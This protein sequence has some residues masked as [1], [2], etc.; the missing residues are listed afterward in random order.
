MTAVALYG[1]P[2]AGKDTVTAALSALDPRFELLTKLKQ[3]TGRSA[4]YRFVTEDELDDLRAQ[5][6][7]LVETRRYGNVYAVDRHLLEEPQERGRVPVVHMGNVTDLRA[8]LSDTGTT[9]L[10]VLLWVP[11]EVCEARSRARNDADTVKRL[12]A[13]DET[14]RDLVDSDLRDLFDVVVRTDRMAPEQVAGKLAA[15][16][17]GP[18]VP[19]RRPEELRTALDLVT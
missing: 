2:T 5:H 7:V 11:R 18:A 17:D 15:T 4:G 19:A 10:R 9:W 8:L 3:G 1:P 14:A 13:W 16:L 12:E 6:R